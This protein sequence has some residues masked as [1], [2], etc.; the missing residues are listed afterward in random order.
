MKQED[1]D[2][3]RIFTLYYLLKWRARY[4]SEL[5]VYYTL[6]LLLIVYSVNA[7]YLWLSMKTKE[8]FFICQKPLLDIFGL[9]HSVTMLFRFCLVCSQNLILIRSR[10]QR[11]VGVMERNA[12]FLGEENSLHL[13]TY[14][15]GGKLRGFLGILSFCLF[16]KITPI[17]YI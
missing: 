8:V 1:L 15:I 9:F 7:C 16:D 10:I 12:G 13:F 2:K 17:F 14:S 4:F 3:W 6:D 5:F 11:L